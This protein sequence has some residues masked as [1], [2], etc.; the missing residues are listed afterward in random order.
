MK[1]KRGKRN[2]QRK[3]GGETSEK[4]FFIGANVAGL[5][6]KVDSLHR[7][8]S[9]FTPGVIFIQE[10]KFKRKNQLQLKDYDCF[11]S[12]RVNSGGGGVFTAVHKALNPTEVHCDDAHD[13][14]VVEATIHKLKRQIRFINGYGPQENQTED[15]RTSSFDQIDLEIKKAKM[16]GALV[17]LQMDSNAKLGS[18]LIP[19]DPWPQ[20]ENGKLLEKVLIENELVLVNGKSLCK[21][22]ITRYRKTVNGIE[23][24]ILDHF[25]V[26][27][28]M[29]SFVAEMIVDEE[30]TYSF[31]KYANK[32]GT[33]NPSK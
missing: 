29:F 15:I 28:E 27:C 33:K 24:S 11:E 6:N 21:G 31:T 8:I 14:V 26:C 23:S 3:L 9:V 12:V 18:T 22:S 2:S 20:S 19:N 32:S 7:I 25:I 13:I 1:V 4:M 30:G 10:S 5:L 16:A 17:C